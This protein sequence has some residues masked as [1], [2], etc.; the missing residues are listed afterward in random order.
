MGYFRIL[1]QYFP[2]GTQEIKKISVT[3][4]SWAPGQELN[5]EPLNPEQEYQVSF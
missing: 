2:E 3:E 5:V 4:A 1:S